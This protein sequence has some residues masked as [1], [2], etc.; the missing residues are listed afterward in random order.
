MRQN[1]V[2]QRDDSII[3][4][5]SMSHIN[6]IHLSHQSITQLND[7][8]MSQLSMSEIKDSTIKQDQGRVQFL[9]KFIK[10]VWEEYQVWK[11]G[12]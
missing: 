10:S 9:I 1:S 4:R 7:S 5:E 11:K 6:E 3:R 12:R 8:H 2:V